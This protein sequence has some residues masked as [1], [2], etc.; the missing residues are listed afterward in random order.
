MH[1]IGG[2][3][4]H[5]I[6]LM[7]LSFEKIR[8]ADSEPAIVRECKNNLNEPGKSNEVALL[9]APSQAGV[10]RNETAD[11]LARLASET[12]FIGLRLIGI[13]KE[14]GG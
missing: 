13:G 6:E 7:Q 14:D 8:R 3:C 12:T 10:E 4:H 2:L 11:E 1:Q 9:W 5:R